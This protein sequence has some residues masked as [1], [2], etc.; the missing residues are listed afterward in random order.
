MN[1]ITYDDR[2]IDRQDY[3]LV[4]VWHKNGK[5]SNSYGLDSFEWADNCA[6]FL[7]YNYYTDCKHYISNIN[8]SSTQEMIYRFIPEKENTYVHGMNSYTWHLNLVGVIEF[9]KKYEN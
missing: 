8:D 4:M 7:L 1:P 9:T 5:Y 6:A 3:A 2:K